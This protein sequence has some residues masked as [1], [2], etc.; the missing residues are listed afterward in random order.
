MSTLNGPVVRLI[1]TAAHTDHMK[2]IVCFEESMWVALS[3]SACK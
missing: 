2:R 3:L 1:L